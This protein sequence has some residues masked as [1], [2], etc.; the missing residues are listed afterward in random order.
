MAAAARERAR[1]LQARLAPFL[2]TPVVVKTETGYALDSDRP[3]SI[4]KVKAFYGNFGVCVKAYAYILSL[5]G[6]RASGSQRS[7][8]AQ[9]QLYHA[10]APGYL[11]NPV[12]PAVHA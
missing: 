1:W 3:L 4:G 11:R 7:G 10:P 9:R 6:K 8:G 2:P 5:G 12:P